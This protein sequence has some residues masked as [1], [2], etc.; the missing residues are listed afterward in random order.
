MWQNQIIWKRLWIFNYQRSPLLFHSLMHSTVITGWELCEALAHVADGVWSPGPG[1]EPGKFSLCV[2]FNET[3]RIASRGWIYLY[4]GRLCANP[5]YA[6]S[7]GNPEMKVEFQM[8]GNKQQVVWASFKLWVT[9]K[10]DVVCFFKSLFHSRFQCMVLSIKWVLINYHNV[11]RE[12]K[13]LLKW[14][15]DCNCG[16]SLWSWEGHPP[17]SLLTQSMKDLWFI[18]ELLLKIAISRAY[19]WY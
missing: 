8:L 10:V 5:C 13:I 3:H 14:C 1:R 19:E 2:K 7:G 18:L 9:P 15:F 17:R 4:N 16:Q 12:G 11:I 6:C